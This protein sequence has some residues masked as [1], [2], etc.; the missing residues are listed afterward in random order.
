MLYAVIRPKDVGGGIVCAQPCAE[1]FSQKSWEPVVFCTN[2]RRAFGAAKD[3]N[4]QRPGLAP[5]RVY[6]VI[7]E[8]VQCE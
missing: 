8:P 2:K 1:L 5:W 7:F 3:L 6:R 4:E